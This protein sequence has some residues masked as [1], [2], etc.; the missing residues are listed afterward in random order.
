VTVE[1]AVATVRFVKWHPRTG[2]GVNAS[3]ELF[4]RVVRVCVGR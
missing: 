4:A 3:Y 1:A 2:M